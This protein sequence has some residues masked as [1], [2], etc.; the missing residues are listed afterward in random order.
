MRSIKHLKTEEL[1]VNRLVQLAV[2]STDP[3]ECELL[4]R[5]IAF[6]RADDGE[7]EKAILSVLEAKRD[8]NNVVASCLFH[9]RASGDDAIRK[10]IHTVLS[11]PPS[12]DTNLPMLCAVIR[13]ISLS[14]HSAEEAQVIADYAFHP[15]HELRWQTRRELGALSEYPRRELIEANRPNVADRN[16]TAHYLE[17]YLRAV[18]FPPE[19][20]AV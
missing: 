9:L 17:L 15:D 8:L 13:L 2:S 5:S 12:E 10:G 7:K 20:Q 6:S 14:K 4:V 19:A 18:P 16:G 11:Q 3:L 1:S